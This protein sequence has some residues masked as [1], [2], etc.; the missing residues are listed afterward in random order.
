MILFRTDHGD[1]DDGDHGEKESIAQVFVP[2]QLAP[3]PPDPVIQSVEWVSTTQYVVPHRAETTLD[4]GHDA[5]YR[6]RHPSGRTGNGVHGKGELE[7]DWDFGSVF[8][9]ADEMVRMEERRLQS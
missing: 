9:N 5:S 4:S 1:E 7:L 2:S 8:E 3:V 6:L